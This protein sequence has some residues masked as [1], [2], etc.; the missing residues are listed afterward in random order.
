MPARLYDWS[1]SIEPLTL[2]SP[3]TGR[4]IPIGWIALSLGGQ[5]Y[6]TNNLYFNDLVTLVRDLPECQRV[7]ELVRSFWPVA[8]R[9]PSRKLR[10]IR[11]EMGK[12]WTGVSEDEPSDWFWVFNGSY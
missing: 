3:V 1:L 10:K 4:I 2:E 7:E 5:G 11:R 6:L 9:S 8:P 12:Y